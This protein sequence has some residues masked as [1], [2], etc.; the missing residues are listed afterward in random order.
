MKYQ[1]ICRKKGKIDQ[2]CDI[3]VG[4]QINGGGWNLQ[5]SKWHIPSEIM[6]DPDY[7]SQ[8]KDYIIGHPELKNQ[9]YE[10]AYQMLGCW[11]KSLEFCHASCLIE[12]TSNYLVPKA[13]NIEEGVPFIEIQ[14]VIP[15]TIKIIDP[16]RFKMKK[17]SVVRKKKITFTISYEYS[18]SLF[19]KYPWAKKQ[20]IAWTDVI[21][22]PIHLHIPCTQAP[23][24]SLESPRSFEDIQRT[25]DNGLTIIY[26]A[27]QP[28]VPSPIDTKY[29]I[30]YKNTYEGSPNCIQQILKGTFKFHRFDCYIDKITRHKTTQKYFRIL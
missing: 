16:K 11:C 20:K 29:Y 14:K 2:A 10:L 9:I 23:F 30:K 3:Y 26:H 28:S 18:Q 22:K 6:R 27:M 7:L 17:C 21:Y 1:R 13:N 19:Q 24:S 5:Q 12:L 15:K 25:L 4:N 8:Y